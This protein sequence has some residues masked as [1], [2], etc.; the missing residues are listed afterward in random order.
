MAQLP[1]T[2]LLNKLFGGTALAVLHALHISPGNARTP[3]PNFVAMQIL[4]AS[5]LIVSFVI[6]R[7]QLSVENPTNLQHVVEGLHQFV[8]GQSQDVIGDH[9]ERFTPFLIALALFILFCNLIGL[10]PGFESPTSTP[11]VPLGCALCAFVYYHWQ[12]FK[13]A[14]LGYPKRFLGSVWWLSWLILP[15]EIFG[16]LARLMSL[17]IRLFA[18]IFAGD[19]VTAV[20]FSLI[21]IAVPVV[22]LGF[23]LGESLLQAYI[24]VLLTTIYLQGAVAGESE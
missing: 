12:G 24:F 11:A 9:S 23:H 19:M 17:T 4:V 2:A 14:G 22:F 16:N 13:N 7:S 8:T 6:A 18:N 15:I 5:I 10:I 21:P 20:F 3:I 1:F